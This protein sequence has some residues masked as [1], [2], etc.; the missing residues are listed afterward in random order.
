MVVIKLVSFVAAGVDLQL[1]HHVW[2]LPCALLGHVAGQRL[3]DRLLQSDPTRF[4]R[5]LGVLLLALG[6]F[7]LIDTLR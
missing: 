2:L 5:G 6:I 3:H 1:V 7:G 4:F